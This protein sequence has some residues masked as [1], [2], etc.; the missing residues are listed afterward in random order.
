MNEQIDEAVEHS[1]NRVIVPAAVT[2]LGAA[3]T[4]LIALL[5]WVIAETLE[6]HQFRLS[7]YSKHDA[8]QDRAILEQRFATLPPPDTRKAISD[9]QTEARWL[10]D[11]VTRLKTII[12][13]IDVRTR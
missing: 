10:R 5:Y 9:L 3:G 12:E 7:G 1:K 2:L 4:A 6:N 8:A 13:R 11:E